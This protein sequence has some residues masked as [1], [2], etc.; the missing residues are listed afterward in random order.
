[1]RCEGKESSVQISGQG[2]ALERHAAE[3]TDQTDFL[4]EVAFRHN[5]KPELNS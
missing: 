5:G 1:M 4:R 3:E 2:D